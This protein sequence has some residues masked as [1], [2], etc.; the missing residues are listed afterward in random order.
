MGVPAPAAPVAPAVGLPAAARAHVAA[1]TELGRRSLPRE[2]GSASALPRVALLQ[3]REQSLA[4]GLPGVGQSGAT[5]QVAVFLESRRAETRSITGAAPEP[6]PVG[7][8][9]VL[10]GVSRLELMGKALATVPSLSVSL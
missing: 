10:K 5:W 2:R 4:S 8:G 3:A 7:S 6:C 1:P 9:L